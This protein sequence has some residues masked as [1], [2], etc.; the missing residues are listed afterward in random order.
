MIAELVDSSQSQ[1]DLE[2]GVTYYTSDSVKI[3]PNSEWRIV[4]EHPQN[5]QSMFYEY[6]YACSF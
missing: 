5:K 6:F 4:G 2:K 1:E 3:S